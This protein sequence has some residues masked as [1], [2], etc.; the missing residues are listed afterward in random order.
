MGIKSRLT[1]SAVA[2]D[3]GDGCCHDDNQNREDGHRRP[4]HGAR[5]MELRMVNIYKKLFTNGVDRGAHDRDVGA[6]E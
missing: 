4:R 6:A 3:R 2:S 1:R 5:W